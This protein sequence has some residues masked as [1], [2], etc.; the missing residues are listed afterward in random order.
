MFCRVDFRRAHM[1]PLALGSLALAVTGLASAEQYRFDDN[2][3]L[4]SGLAGGSLERFNRAN[5]VDPGSYHVDIYLNGSYASRARV[6]FRSHNDGVEPCFSERFLRQTLGA[7]AAP[8]TDEV[9]RQA[10]Q[11]LLERLPGSS[12]T[13][14]TARLR[15]DLSVPQ[16]LLDLKPRG[17]VSPDEWDAGSTMGFV[18][19]DASLYRSSFDGAGNGHSDYGYLGLSGGINLGLWRLRHQSNYTYSSYA[20]NTRSDWNSIRTYVQRAVPGLRSELTLGE[21][22]TEGNLFG[23]LGYRGVRLAS[24]DRMLPESQRRYA[25]QVRGTANSNARV[26]IS[27]NGKKIHEAVVAPGPF[28][29]DDLYGTAYDG[30]LDVQVIEADGSVS[31]FSVPFSAV[32]ESMRPGISRYAATLGQARQYGD[33]NDLFGDFTYQRGLTNALTANLGARMAED[34]LALLG[35]GVFA[36]RYGAFGLNTTFSS[37]TVE[38]GQ[39]KQGWR[40]GLNYS[41]T[42]QPTQTTLTLAGYRYSTEGYRDLGDALSARHADQRH[43][44]WNSSSY[45]QRNQFTVLVNQG[46]GEYGNLYLSGATSDYYDGKSRDTQLQFGYSNTWRR[47]SYNLAYSRQQTTW[48][49]DL[50][51]DYDPSLPPQYNL[52]RGSERNDTLTLTLSLPL[53]SSSRAPNFSAMASRRSGDSRGSSYQ[54]GLNGTLGEDRSLSYAINAGRDSQARGT[55][56]NGSLQKQTAVATVNAGYAESASYRQL[57]AGLRGAAVLHR[58]GLTLGPYVGDTFALIEAKGAS[59]AGVRGGQGARVDGNGYAVVP[60][61]S[62]YRYN[63]VSLDPQG[64]GETAELVETERKIAPYAGAAVHV[65]FKTLTGHPLLI[66]AQL[67]DGG[68]LPLG[69]DVLDRRGVTIGMVGQ[70]GQV[71][72]RAE[73]DQGRLRVQWG[74]RPE[75]ACLLDY[76]LDASP[77][78]AGA[79]DQAVIRLDGICTPEPEAP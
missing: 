46:L 42:F 70:G 63:P 61:L 2:L 59:G 1:A 6:E 36:T 65:R 77:R 72:A 49:R 16:A 50:D 57:N 18:N 19:Y 79:S 40:V 60:S 7:H 12:F 14:D 33:G 32:P 67:P 75:D 5:Q 64:M 22:Y 52:R 56:F 20:G 3:L 54:T 23:S 51:N 71:Y 41:R 78:E 8:N 25:P 24:D 45:K 26:V 31:R 47:L 11:G 34:Y 17:Y 35:G 28:V 39:R 15:L 27:Q 21:S 53:G 10:C 62:P 76:D 29:I 74:E 4:G 9:D 68:A 66:Q 43:D 13:L 58:G 69:A 73:G 48:Y 38:N 37:A 30:D 44:T 55:D